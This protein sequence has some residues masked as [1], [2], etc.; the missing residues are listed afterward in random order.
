MQEA[1]HLEPARI[2]LRQGEYFVSNGTPVA[3][4]TVLGSCVSVIF[5]SPG[6]GLGGINHAVL[7]DMALNCHGA[8]HNPGWYVRSS[9]LHVLEQLQ[10]REA[11]TRELEVKVFGGSKMYSPEN[12]AG[13][14][15]SSV[16]SKNVE[17]VLTTLQEVGISPK[18]MEVG[19]QMGRKLIFLPDR[20]EVWVKRIPS[21]FIR[22]QKDV[23]P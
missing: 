18:V 6:L 8:K 17:R 13:M 11:R 15:G 5:Y 22:G 14:Q 10:A 9:I 23:Q 3:V 1:K 21:S 20:G 4:T 7:P 16:G 19:G 2:F 12:Y